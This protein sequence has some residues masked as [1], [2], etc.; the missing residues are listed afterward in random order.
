MQAIGTRVSVGG[1]CSIV[2]EDG[3]ALDAQ[4]AVEKTAKKGKAGTFEF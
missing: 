4:P 3:A 2:I 1:E